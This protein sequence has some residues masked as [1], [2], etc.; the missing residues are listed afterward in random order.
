MKLA[1]RPLSWLFQS[2]IA[3]LDVGQMLMG[4]LHDVG[5]YIKPTG[6]NERNL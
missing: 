5:S 3:K 1:N 2:G 4:K 6:H